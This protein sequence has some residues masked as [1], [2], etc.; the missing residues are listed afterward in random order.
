[1]QQQAGDNLELNNHQTSLKNSHSFHLHPKLI[2]SQI[3]NLQNR[4]I[5]YTDCNTEKKK[6]ISVTK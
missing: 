3:N 2:D 6:L 5:F 1:M 4:E